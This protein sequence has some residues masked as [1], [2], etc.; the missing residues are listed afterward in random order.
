[1]PGRHV[2]IARTNYRMESLSSCVVACFLGTGIHR[3][4]FGRVGR[5]GIELSTR[6]PMKASV[7]CSIQYIHAVYTED[8]PLLYL[9]AYMMSVF[10]ISLSIMRNTLHQRRVNCRV[11][12]SHFQDCLPGTILFVG[13][14]GVVKLCIDVAGMDTELS[15]PSTRFMQKN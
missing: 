7:V 2:L 8:V 12:F 4:S 14:Q 10:D 6:T 1:M 15:T 3:T 5:P 9:C 13:M 11:K